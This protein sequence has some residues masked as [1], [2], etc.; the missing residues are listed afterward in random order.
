[1]KKKVLMVTIIPMMMFF[2]FIT[3]LSVNSRKVDLFNEILARTNSNIEECGVTAVFTTD[4]NRENIVDQILKGLDFYD[5][6]NS[7]ILKNEQTYC[8]EFGK[9]SV[10]GYIETMQYE[11]HNIVKV[12][13]VKGERKNSLSEL[14]SKL[15]KSIGNQY[16][17]IKYYEY[18]KGKVENSDIKIV[19]E[20]ILNVLK[21]YG[22]AN[23]D[24]VSIENGYST[25]A[26]TK[27]YNSIKSNGKLIDFNYA[28]CKYSS[29][30][31]IIIGTPE[32]IVTY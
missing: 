30:N 11:N 23:I 17:D 15:Q 5:G 28:V 14:K 25:T 31:Y 3:E 18:L 20:Q 16:I 7:S 1:M 22:V 24:T 9:N 19:N 13:I 2:L 6:W 10:K 4:M 8:V 27:Q 12:N 26:Y 32:L 29:G 21:D